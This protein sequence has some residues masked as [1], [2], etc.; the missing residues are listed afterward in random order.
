VFAPAKSRIHYVNFPRDGLSVPNICFHCESPACADACP[1]DAIS[2]NDIGTVVVDYAACTGCAECVEACP[3]GM[4]VLN[5]EGLAYKCDFCG[6][7]PEC[8]K[9]CQPMAI[10][11]DAL[12][13]G[14]LKERLFQMSKKIA[15]G[16]PGNKR[17]A[18]AAIFK[19]LIR[20]IFK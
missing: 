10:V 3:Y 8:V 1:M 16:E 11:Y 13:E 14:T 4:I 9:V 12:N 15:E 5:N 20:G 17:V 6:G 2:R 7:D 19:D 18:M